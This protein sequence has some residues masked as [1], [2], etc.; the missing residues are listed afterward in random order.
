MYRNQKFCKQKVKRENRTCKRKAKP[1]SDYCSFHL[2][3]QEKEARNELIR[4]EFIFPRDSTQKS[5]IER[6]KKRKTSHTKDDDEE[7]YDNE[8]SNDSLNHKSSLILYLRLCNSEKLNRRSSSPRHQER[9]KKLLASIIRKYDKTKDIGTL[10]RFS[11]KKLCDLAGQVIMT[12]I[13]LERI[14][15]ALNYIEEESES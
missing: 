14:E 1:G 2:R 13:E 5:L 6:K 8:F 12:P 15:S 11:K 7:R 10:M 4:Q 9:I 3:L